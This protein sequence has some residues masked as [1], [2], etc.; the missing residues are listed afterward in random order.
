[1]NSEA[2]CSV[3]PKV[4]NSF[5]FLAIPS[6]VVYS[7]DSNRVVFLV[8]L[9]PF[10]W[11]SPMQSV[12]IEALSSLTTPGEMHTLWGPKDDDPTPL[13]M[14]INFGFVPLGMELD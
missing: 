8:S 11:A 14:T 10:L 13:R 9:E 3:G 2:C 1:M 7:F 4:Q 5:E 6:K 12:L